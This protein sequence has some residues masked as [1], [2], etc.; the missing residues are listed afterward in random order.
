MKAIKK[1]QKY[2]L[3]LALAILVVYPASVLSQIAVYDFTSDDEG[4]TV[5]TVGAVPG[6]WEY[7]EDNGQWVSQGSVAGCGGP[8]HDFLS[9]PDCI[10]T[11]AGDVTVSIDHRHA[12]EG[13]MWD[14]AQLWI[15]VNGGDYTDVGKDAFTANGYTDVAIVGNGIA[16]GQN[17]FGETSAG[18]ADGSYITTSAS[19]G[20][21][22]AGDAI[23]VR[24]VALYD[25]C[26]TGTNPNWVID[27]V[28]FFSGDV[29]YVPA[30]VQLVQSGPGG[31]TV[32]V[33]DTDSSQVDL[34]TI[35]VKFNGIDVVPVK[36]KDGG[37][38]TILYTADPPLPVADPNYVTITSPP[39]AVTS[40]YK[41][42]SN[43]A[44]TVANLPE[45]IEGKVVYT[46]P[47]VADVPLKNAADVAGNIA[48]CDR[49]AT[50]FDRKAQY[51]FEAGA[52]ANIVANNRPGAPIVMGTGRT[53]FYE[54]GPHFMISQDDGMKIKPYLDQGVTISI[55]PG[56]KLEV[57]MK[58][59]TGNTIEA[60]FRV[61]VPPYTSVSGVYATDDSI[62][63]DPGILAYVTQISTSQSES[64]TH[65]H[66]NAWRKALTQF[67]GKLLDP[68]GAF[69]LNEADID[70]VEEWSYY[71]EI[72]QTVN[73]SQD[74]PAD[75]G[76]F[77]ATGGKEDQPIPGIPGWYDSNDGIVAGFITLLDLPV[78]R[79]TLGVNSDDGFRATFQA[80]YDELYPKEVAVR[81]TTG[82]TLFTVF[83]E[84]AGLYPFKLLWWEGTGG[85]NV[86]LFSVV[87]GNKILVNDPDEAD[88]IKAYVPLGAVSDESTAEIVSTGR[89]SVVDV[90]P[91][92]GGFTTNMSVELHVSEGAL[93]TLVSGSVKFS[94]NGESVAFEIVEEDGL[95]K[96]VHVPTSLG[97]LKASVEFEDSAGN[98]RKVDWSF[99]I[100]EAVDP[101]GLNMLAYFDFDK[102]EDG[103]TYDSVRNIEG[104]LTAL[105]TINSGAGLRGSGLDSTNDPDS[106]GGNGL[107]IEYGEILNL[108]STVDAVTF[109][110]WAKNVNPT[111][112]SYSSAFHGVSFGTVNNNGAS[113]KVPVSGGDISWDTANQSVTA[114]FEG[115]YSTWN[116]YAFVKDKSNKK[117]Y[118]N[119]VLLN[120]DESLHPLPSDFS[121][122]NVLGDL[123]AV[124]GL[125][126]H[127]DEFAIFASALSESQVMDT[128]TGQMF[129]TSV[130]SDLITV[131]PKDGS[132]EQ[133]QSAEFSLELA[134]PENSTVIWFYKGKPAA[135]GLPYTLSDL[136]DDDQG[137]EVKA[138]VFGPKSYQYSDTAT[139]T[140]TPDVTTP[141]LTGASAHKSMSIFHLTFSE[142]MDEE[143]LAETS[144]YTIEGLTVESAEASGP[145]SVKITTST[146]ALDTVYQIAFDVADI[147]NN[148]L[149]GSTS[150][151]TF[152]EI[153]GYADIEYYDGIDGTA[154]SI[155]YDDPEFLAGNFSSNIHIP[156]T[157]TR[158]SFG[159]W[160]N[161]RADNY[162]AKMS[163][164]I[165]APETGEYRFFFH[166]DDNGEFYLS[167]DESM[168]NVEMLCEVTGS[169][170]A[171]VLDDDNLRSALVSLEQ[172]KKY[173]FE[174]FWKEGTGGDNC[175]L[176]WRL[177]SET[178]AFDTPPDASSGIP[179]K[180]LVSYSPEQF[181]WY[182]S[183]AVSGLGTIQRVTDL[184]TLATAFGV[185]SVE[186]A[187]GSPY[188]TIFAPTDEAFAALPDGVL[189]DLLANP[190]KLAEV[191]K[192]HIINNDPKESGS[193]WWTADVLE[194]RAYTTALGKTVT[195]SKQQ[196]G[197]SYETHYAK[198]TDTIM[199][200]DAKV[201]DELDSAASS[202]IIIDKVL[203]PPPD[204]PVAKISELDSDGFELVAEPSDIYDGENLINGWVNAG[205]AT[206]FELKDGYV[207]L[208]GAANNGWLQH[209]N[210]ESVWE[211]GVA[212][213]GSWTA[214]ISVR[215]AADDGNAVVIWGANGAERSILQVNTGNTQAFNGAVLD[216]N[217]NTDAFH[218]FR[219]AFEAEDGLY[220]VW[221]DGVLLTADG[222]A[223][224][225]GTGANRFIVGDC[226][227]SYLMT[228]V[229]LAY[230]RY[231]T[232][233]AFSPVPRGA[234][235]TESVTGPTIVDFGMLSGDASYEFYFKAIKAGASTAIAG[236]N[237]FAIKLDQW[238]EQGVFGT[239][240]FGVV[241]NVFT[242]V[243][244][245]SV[246]SV[247]DR[248][249][250]VVVV[251]DTAAGETRLYVDGDHVGV[252]AGNFELA[253]EG[254]V[255]GARI[256]A[257][258]D[259]MG[260][261]SVMHK[262]AT[263]NNALTDEQIAELAAAASG[264][265]A[266][267]ISVVN[268]GD[269]TVTVTFE[270]TL[271]SA[272]TVNGPWSDLGGAS[273]LTIPADQAAQF[274]RARN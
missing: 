162:G 155:L 196:G 143:S 114:A 36:E 206:N 63:G 198:S 147:S 27:K 183:W 123:N 7:N 239:T 263:Y 85:A 267:T 270:G 173:Y 134:D 73:L 252:L 57:S 42:D 220:Y 221:R 113:A 243:E 92:A 250:H 89:A 161:A 171:F 133:L 75:A 186:I 30:T 100:E 232:T 101:E 50:Y 269:G 201:L 214:E 43:H 219:L 126:G 115:T 253:G 104:K 272:P 226:C 218:T 107:R 141:S 34:D 194:E 118:V 15:S 16:K 84:K 180:H 119:G 188:D 217:D 231:D 65:L 240:A 83:I 72:I 29:P 215:L 79:T 80:D 25:D 169:A 116:H 166:S 95:K 182:G 222:L 189:D 228:T 46:D 35:S 96:I 142:N 117:I 26:S 49:G 127:F 40:L 179:G 12:F 32:Q 261:G 271:Q 148:K 262:W 67:N 140:V 10:V 223:K 109:T 38:A 187:I 227:S 146:Q 233:G 264:G 68:D 132:G 237:A 103:K 33:T 202:V 241:D 181:P 151:T 165:I 135:D 88:A 28:A 176:A 81:Q 52:V 8:Y 77:N 204:E 234:E 211:K 184:S 139:L 254:K 122:I 244:G 91:S 274:G 238:N 200:N 87:D 172:G 13:G 56:H 98:S 190:D 160:D 164:W 193:N 256:N 18:Y 3:D 177:P 236:N 2:F 138:L 70:S 45:A 128:M 266:P 255:M 191:I 120:E 86:E 66:D 51:A 24:F 64:G 178:D 145:T 248:D 19:L 208:I 130:S 163:G 110:F 149:S 224:Q 137:A 229:D 273:P 129:G 105:A 212:D 199:V 37:V 260:E 235:S 205:G 249:V 157:N 61:V 111:Q 156:E 230:I 102:E 144:N 41:V 257:N 185:A 192:Y 47:A 125:E 209:D 97:E 9:S 71:P 216:T 17:G 246:A 1:T 58:D 242:P 62:K 251:N 78:G 159:G 203:I 175:G 20:T 170:N 112:P 60:S 247:F 108:A 174:A 265:D 106:T 131:Q 22:A 69:Y 99:F 11:A 213:G 55:S 5:E 124:D 48:L 167:T 225:A 259:P 31:F 93:G 94:I 4:F 245:K 54:E 74:A 44:I 121:A 268:N 152:K 53:L 14:S 6:P 168:N 136:S 210:D 59:S 23:S 150:V 82:E 258:T 39:E 195:I 207:S 76:A 158:L 153:N 90:V 21:F 197:T 154:L